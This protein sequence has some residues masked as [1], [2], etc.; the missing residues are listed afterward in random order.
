MI[1]TLCSMMQLL[2]GSYSSVGAASRHFWPNSGT[3]NGTVH[4][5]HNLWVQDL[6]RFLDFHSTKQGQP[7]VDS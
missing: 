2:K 3:A 4:V 7:L 6:D 1:Q 5:F